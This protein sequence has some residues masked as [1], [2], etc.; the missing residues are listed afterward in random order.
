MDLLLLLVLLV[1]WLLRLMATFLSLL[2]LVLFRAWAGLIVS[3]LLGLLE[4]EVGP[5][6]VVQL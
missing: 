5:E 6:G 1:L 2:L 3:H 4:S